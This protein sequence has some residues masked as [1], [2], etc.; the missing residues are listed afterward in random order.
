MPSTRPFVELTRHFLEGFFRPAFLGEHGADALRRL[1]ITLASA[2]AMLGMFLPYPLLKKYMGLSAMDSGMPYREA[3][4]SDQILLI[5]VPMIV[6]GLAM[7]LVAPSLYVDDAD[8]LILKPLPVPSGTVFAAKLAAVALFIAIFVVATNTVGNIWFPAIS[9]GRWATSGLLARTGAHTA[10]SL[11]A[12]SFVPLAIAMVQGVPLTLLPRRIASTMSLILQAVL[13]CGLTA[14]VPLLLRM[15]IR[16]EVEPWM[17][18][19]PPAWFMGVA[20]Y[21]RGE[22]D[23][24]FARLAGIGVAAYI[25]ALLTVALC[26]VGSYLQFGRSSVTVDKPP[27]TRWRN[28]LALRLAPPTLAGLGFITATIARNRLN[29]MVLAGMLAIGAGL[30]LDTLLAGWYGGQSRLRD[31][32][33]LVVYR[34]IAPSL[35]LVLTAIVGVRASF[36]LPVAR[37]ANWVFRLI[38]PVPVRT[39]LLAS[40]ESWFV[41]V[42]AIAPLCAGLPLL[43][44]TLGLARTALCAPVLLL[45]ALTMVELVLLRWRRVPFTCSYIPGKEHL[46]KVALMTLLAYWVCV[47]VAGHLVGWAMLRP[48]RVLTTCGVLLAAYAWLRRRRI[49][50]RAQATL[51]FEDEMPDVIRSLRLSS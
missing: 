21:L 28:P 9:G 51:E 34:A 7:T 35:M 14:A 2:I 37:E 46:V 44:I 11:L 18:F 19:A 33:R 42:G 17:V 38:D 45:V 6:V 12:T 22:T 48:S 43:L 1:L 3:M 41:L 40:V 39:S 10:A 15:P 25:G 16:L 29:V 20:H 4:I 8:F 31:P 49:A 26:Y 50:M 24:A 5:G 27:R 32:S 23:P 47:F 30:V 36:L 13:F